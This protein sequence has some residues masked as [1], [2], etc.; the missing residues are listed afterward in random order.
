MD[1]TFDY[2]KGH[3]VSLT[4]RSANRS[5]IPQKET[6]DPSWAVSCESQSAPVWSLMSP[7]KIPFSLVSSSLQG[8]I[9]GSMILEAI[10]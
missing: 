7:S 6:F 5:P 10:Q 4:L 3:Y 8:S 2:Q 1:P 9:R